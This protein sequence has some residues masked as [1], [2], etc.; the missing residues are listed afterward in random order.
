MQSYSTV[1]I[2]LVASVERQMS[3]SLSD[4]TMGMLASTANTV[5]VY[6]VRFSHF[7]NAT[8][9]KYA[10]IKLSTLLRH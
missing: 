7:I 1:N 4:S 10:C 5:Y 3:T 8:T 9:R 6:T 2:S